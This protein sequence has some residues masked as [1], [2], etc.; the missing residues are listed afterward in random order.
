K[1]KKENYADSLE[2]LGLANLADPTLGGRVTL[3][4][5]GDG[6]IA[7][8]D[9]RLEGQWP[10]RWSIRQDARVWSEP[11][12]VALTEALVLPPVG[13]YGRS[14]V[15]IDALESLCLN[16]KWKAPQAGDTITLPD[17]NT[18]AWERVEAGAD[19]WMA[20]RSLGG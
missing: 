19:G 15:H 11:I 13:R 12:P 8:V 17:G 2:E 18:Q 9:V 1:A 4:R 20:H 10:H 6:F 16:G 3:Q 5:T 14:V 7:S